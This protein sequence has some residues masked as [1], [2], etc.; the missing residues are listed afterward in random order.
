MYLISIYFDEKTESK[1]RSYMKQIARHTENAH[2]LDGDVPPHITIGG[3]KTNSEEKAKELF[4][5]I[6]KKVS[7]KSIQWVSVGTFLPGVLYITPIL[8]EYLHELSG[9]YNNEVK[10][11]DNLQVDQ[12]YLL[13]KWLPHTTLGKH[14]TGL[15]MKKAFEVMQSQFAP[16][17]GRVVKIGL[18][19]TNPYQDIVVCELN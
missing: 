5:N 4:F 6:T 8:N 19:K 16:F 11:Y 13:F 2:M 10:K 17:E 15:Q 12:R 7:S 1:I 18:A 14:L 3:F 9:I